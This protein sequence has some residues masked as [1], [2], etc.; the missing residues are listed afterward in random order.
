[1][2][3]VLLCLLVAG[4]LI[5]KHPPDEY[6]WMMLIGLGWV[7]GYLDCRKF[8]HSDQDQARVLP[9]DSNERSDDSSIFS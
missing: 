6:G 1:M 3:F 5:S 7:T 8:S 4:L 2:Y 9:P